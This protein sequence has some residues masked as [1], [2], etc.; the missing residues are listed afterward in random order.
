MPDVSC[1][2]PV[3][4][5]LNCE[6]LRYFEKHSKWC[7]NFLP[8]GGNP[9]NRASQMLGQSW[10]PGQ[11]CPSQQAVLPRPCL[12]VQTPCCCP[13]LQHTFAES[14]FYSNEFGRSTTMNYPYF[15]LSREVRLNYVTIE[16][17][18]SLNIILKPLTN[19]KWG[20]KLLILLISLLYLWLFRC[21]CGVMSNMYF[22]SCQRLL[23]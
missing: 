3:V 1:Y 15:K 14:C 13:F 5:S 22:G 8:W 21:C 6:H 2:L 9:W 11:S 12:S 23:R 20:V 17:S 10:I 19:I 4:G 7:Q 16:G 18:K